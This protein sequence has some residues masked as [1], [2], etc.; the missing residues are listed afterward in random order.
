ME[1]SGE[2]VAPLVSAS[3]VRGWILGMVELADLYLLDQHTA[4][5]DAI[6]ANSTS[7]SKRSPIAY[8]CFH[9]ILASPIRIFS[10]VSAAVH[11]A[12][13]YHAAFSFTDYRFQSHGYPLFRS[14]G[15]GGR[16]LARQVDILGNS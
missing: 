12:N 8:F 15:R 14:S 13:R 9:R 2:L 10:K 3:A 7:F 16:I 6:G 11:G 4:G 1:R 5:A